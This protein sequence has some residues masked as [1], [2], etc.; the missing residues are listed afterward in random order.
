MNY[1]EI[2]NNYIIDEWCQNS[3]L[4]YDEVVVYQV[5]T[6]KRPYRRTTI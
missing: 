6:D 4:I 1:Q 3:H 2:K 5:M